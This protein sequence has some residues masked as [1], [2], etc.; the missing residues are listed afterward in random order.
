MRR[1]MMMMRKRM[2]SGQMK[3]FRRNILGLREIRYRRA[4][5][6]WVTKHIREK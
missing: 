2:S 5:I 6:E 3:G 4:G 1:M